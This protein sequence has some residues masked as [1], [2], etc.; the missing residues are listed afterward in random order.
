M[1]ALW[2]QRPLP[3]RALWSARSCIG[4]EG[5]IATETQVLPPPPMDA[6]WRMNGKR[7][8]LIAE[9]DARVRD[10]QRFFLEKS[11]FTVEFA[12]D[13]QAAFERALVLLPAVVVTE[14]LI[15]PVDGLTLCRQLKENPLTSGIPVVV[16]SI[17]S[18]ASRAIEAG[19]N[20]FLR[21]PMVESTFIGAVVS[22][23]AAQPTHGADQ[24]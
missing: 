11:G 12:D 19:A 22:L 7:S 16:F 5:T 10:L 23:M 15:T 4:T 6:P 8:V 24:R 20:V 2:V 3:H 21:K 1:V 17:L 13:G 14:I 9:R 18:A